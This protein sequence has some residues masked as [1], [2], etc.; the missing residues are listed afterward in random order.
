MA[1]LV[2]C[3]SHCPDCR[4]R[5]D[6]RH[7]FTWRRIRDL[8]RI[9]QCIRLMLRVPKWFC[10]NPN[11]ER[12]IFTERLEWAVPYSRRTNRT[13]HVLTTLMLAMNA[14]EAAR[15]CPTIDWYTDQSRYASQDFE[16]CP[17][18]F[19]TARYH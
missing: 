9:Q 19:G 10:D 6:R 13:D 12:I 2:S 18:S 5:C 17:C 14:K 1:H 16:T 4:T 7:G 11:C 3:T 8:F 15:V